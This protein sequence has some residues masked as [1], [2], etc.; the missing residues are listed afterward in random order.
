MHLEIFFIKGF[1][2]FIMDNLMCLM[3]ILESHNQ[4]CFKSVRHDEYPE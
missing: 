4:K 3:Y 2:N 1:F